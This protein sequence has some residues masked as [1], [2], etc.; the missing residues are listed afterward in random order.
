MRCTRLVYNFDE[1]GFQPSESRLRNVVSSKGKDKGLKSAP[2]LPESKEY[3]NITL[4]NVS[5]QIK[6]VV[7]DQSMVVR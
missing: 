4:S 6:I 5:L 7:S 2:D 1:C 3:E